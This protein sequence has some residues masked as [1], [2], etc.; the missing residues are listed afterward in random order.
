MKCGLCSITFRKLSVEA[1]I[2]LCKQAKT[3]AIEWGGD[4]HAPP[5]LSAAEL[6][7][8]KAK[9]TDSGLFISSYGSYYNLVDPEDEFMKNLEAAATLEAPVMR[10]WPPKTASA[11]ASE[12]DYIKGAEKA[13]NL[14]QKAAEF[15]IDIAFEFHQGCMTD[16]A[17]KALELTTRAPHPNLKNYYQ[18]YFNEN[19]DNAGELTTLL[20]HLAHVHVYYWE[21]FNSRYRLEEGVSL[22]QPLIN[23][24]SESNFNGTLLLEFVKNNS[25]EQFIEDTATL[26]NMI[27][28][29]P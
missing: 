19:R 2:A 13:F 24:L 23:Q 21:N 20:P 9:T 18:A 12:Q 27:R 22:W 8:I 4:V 17:D 3:E 26:R 29:A 28:N 5:S 10:I 6:K 16:K 14:A 15:N 25:P 11:E 1:V 7:E